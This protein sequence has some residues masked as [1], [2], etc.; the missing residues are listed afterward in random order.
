MVATM[1]ATQGLIA[2]LIFR[3]AAGL[4]VPLLPF[5]AALGV[6]FV[7]LFFYLTLTL[8]LG[9]MAEKRGPVVGFPIAFLF[10]QQYLAGLLPFLR[11]LIPLSLT[12]PLGNE[13][14]I[15]IALM[16]GVRPPTL[17]PLVSTTVAS[18]AFVVVALWVFQRQ[19]L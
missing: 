4:K 16:T 17:L 2:Y 18:V 8:M 13:T 19:E 7:N 1:V 15:A 6:H 11:R 5:A 14:S 12:L 9:A 10:G 3:F